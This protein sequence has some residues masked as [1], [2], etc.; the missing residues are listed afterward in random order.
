MGYAAGVLMQNSC[1]SMVVAVNQ[2]TRETKEWRVG[3]APLSAFFLPNTDEVPAAH[4]K[5][6]HKS[7]QA[8]SKMTQDPTVDYYKNPGPTQ[9]FLPELTRKDQ[10]S[11]KQQIDFY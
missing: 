4:V 7:Y 6:S 9:F 1:S 2:V 5:L 10:M 8:M 3:G 11:C